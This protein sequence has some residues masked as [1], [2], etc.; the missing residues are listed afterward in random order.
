[1]NDER[2]VR[3]ELIEKLKCM[4]S[5]SKFWMSREGISEEILEE[6]EKAHNQIRKLIQQKPEIDDMEKYV[7][8][9][10]RRLTFEEFTPYEIDEAKDFITQIIR[11]AGVKTKK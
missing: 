10:A 2:K 6:Y 5:C 4:L 9:K 1:M 3:E 7:E 8:E 11:D